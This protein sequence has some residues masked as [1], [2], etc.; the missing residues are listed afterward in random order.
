MARRSWP[1]V[2]SQLNGRELRLPK[3]MSRRWRAG[4]MT[5]PM[6]REQGLEWLRHMVRIRRFEERAAELYQL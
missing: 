3:V 1:S 2:R 4:V 5:I 6:T